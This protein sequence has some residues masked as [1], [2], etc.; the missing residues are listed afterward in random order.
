[1][2]RPFSE[3]IKDILDSRK[4]RF[5][6][7][8]ID[9]NSSINHFLFI[10]HSSILRMFGQ[11]LDELDECAICCETEDRVFRI[12]TSKCTHR[13][14]ICTECVNRHIIDYNEKQILEI[15]CPT[16]G[17]NKT[18]ERLDVKNIAKEDVFEKYNNC[19]LF[20]L[21]LKCTVYNIINALIFCSDMIFLLIKMQLKRFR[22][23]DG[24]KYLVELDKFTQE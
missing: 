12:I 18:M 2:T 20:F 1:M 5:K 17:C 22:N 23:S 24:A 6:D 16:K 19:F 10:S 14:V 13:V 21:H 9:T 15:P 11:M 3:I 8:V 4:I 7:L